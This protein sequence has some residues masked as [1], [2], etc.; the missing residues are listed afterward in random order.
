M[1]HQP[2]TSTRP[3]PEPEHVNHSGPGGTTAAATAAPRA[4]RPRKARPAR[5]SASNHPTTGGRHAELRRI[6]RITSAAAIGVV[7]LLLALL[8]GFQWA[9][10]DQVR[11][12]VH[13]WGVDLGGMT[14]DEAHTALEDAASARTGQPLR[15]TD[16]DMSWRMSAAELGL[17]M[18][19]DRVADAAFQTGREGYGPSRVAL[20]W[21][22]RSEPYELGAESVAVHGDLLDAEL[23]RLAA[24]IYQERV[25]PWLTVDPYNGVTFV[26]AQVGRELDVRASRT[27]ILEAL[28][29]GESTVAL[30]IV[31]DHPSATDDQ[32]TAARQQLDNIW[33]APIEVVAAGEV[34]PLRPDQ[35][36]TWLTVLQ[37]SAGKPASLVLD[38]AWVS[39]VVQEISFSTDRLPQSPR[40]WWDVGG[41]LIKTADGTPGQ[42]LDTEGSKQLISAAFTGQNAANRVDLPVAI[43]NPPALPGDLNALGIG[44]KI[45]EASTPYGGGLAERMHNIELA[46]RLLNGTVILPG[47]TFSFNAEIGPMTLDAGF[48]MGYGIAQGDDGELTTIPAEAGGICQVATTVFQPVFWTG[49]AIEQRSTHSYWINNYIYQGF[50]GLDATVEPTVGLDFKWTNNSPTAVLLEAATD[51]QMFTVRLYGTPPPWKVEVVPPVIENVVEAKDEIV[52]EGTTTVPEGQLRTIEHAQDGFD[53][54]IVR[55]VTENG[56]TRSLEYKTKY[57]PSRNVVL[58]GTVDGTLPEGWVPPE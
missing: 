17:A 9:E 31:E 14:P 43:T 32:F 4:T 8:L 57:G 40:L 48:Q 30:S 38:D 2:T 39:D 24:E 18:D 13:A 42:Q 22:I 54:T 20:L 45:A 29:S 33:D 12:G 53:V 51:G 10:R 19:V 27:A 50:V 41:A 25:D 21:R 28:G 11:A 1:T 5:S 55:K 26:S 49:Y 6:A 44:A 36:A 46:A 37:P 7:V 3:I 52:Y 35:I 15:L 34:W 56:E 47:Q 16:G 58:V 23:A